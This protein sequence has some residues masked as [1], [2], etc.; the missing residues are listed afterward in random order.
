[1]GLCQVTGAAVRMSMNV[2][3]ALADRDRD[4]PIC[5]GHTLVNAELVITLLLMVLV[6]TSMNVS[7]MEELV[8]PDALTKMEDIPVHVQRNI[9]K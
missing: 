4:A 7:K 3:K 9:T 1:M 6:V 5:Q 2:F 8:H